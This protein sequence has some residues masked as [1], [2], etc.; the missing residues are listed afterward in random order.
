M[1][2]VLEAL[3]ALRLAGGA[4]VA[5]ARLLGAAAALRERTGMPVPRI[6]HPTLTRVTAAL[7]RAL[8]T[9]RLAAEQAAGAALPRHELVVEALRSLPPG[10]PSGAP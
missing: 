10:N 2:S 3:A 5:A 8:G 1:A 6:E 7:R 4:P 9:E